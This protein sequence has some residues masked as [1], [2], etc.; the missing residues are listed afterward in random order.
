MVCTANNLLGIPPEF[1]RAGRFDEIFFVDLPNKEQRREV[2]SVLLERKSRKPENFDLDPIIASSD[3]YSPAEIEKGINNAMFVAYAEQR[4]VIT[5]DVVSE[6]GKFKPL[7][8]SRKEEIQEM[9]DWALGENGVGGRA[10]LANSTIA[11]K[12]F[13]Y[14]DNDRAVDISEE[15]L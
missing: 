5:K 1:M 10:R 3:N 8:E 14:K 7:Y 12:T 6:L 11:V 2:I 15:D 13:A 9:R 4:E